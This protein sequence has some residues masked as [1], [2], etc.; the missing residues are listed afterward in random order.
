MWKGVRQTIE[1]C[2]PAIFPS[3]ATRTFA[4]VPIGPSLSLSPPLSIES[5]LSL[6][7]PRLLPPP[8]SRRRKTDLDHIHQGKL[9]QIQAAAATVAEAD[10]ERMLRRSHRIPRGRNHGMQAREG[11]RPRLLA[12]PDREY[13]PPRRQDGVG[14]SDGRSVGLLHFNPEIFPRAP[15]FASR[16]S[17]PSIRNF[18]EI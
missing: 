2:S 7:N 6:S 3:S 8:C 13:F 14:R 1:S 18:A 11:T 5:P 10:G 16:P 15:A 4:V 17:A 9:S 12:Y